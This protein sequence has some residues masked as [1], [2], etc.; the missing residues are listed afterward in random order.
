MA[1]NLGWREAITEVLT[2]AAAPMH[3][4][5]I[6]DQINKLELREDLGATPANSVA[7]II[8]TSIKDFGSQSPFVR[9][10]RG[11]YSLKTAQTA[12]AVPPIVDEIEETT[13]PDTGVINAFGMFWDR[14]KVLWI[15]NPKILGQQ[16][17]NAVEVDFCD[18]KGVYLLHD[19]QGV[20]YVGRVTDQSLGRRLYQHTVDRLN[21]RWGRFSWFGVYRVNP[22]A[23]LSKNDGTT[24]LDMDV[25][26]VTME[27]VLIEGLE[28]R[29]NRKRG[30][31]VQALEFLQK[32]D[33][34]LLRDRK[35][36]V[37]R[38]LLE[39]IQKA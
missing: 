30:D 35:V 9:V 12:A 24:S 19:A 33:P 29:Q 16:Q 23:S 1:Q 5:D 28:P 21:G 32:E 13:S 14:S 10:S 38:E 4:A 11:V 20:V 3:Y 18:Q 37:A 15:P 36:A 2:V 31:D 27:A 22:D 6:A 26:I 34:N 25:V 17:T 8:T 7:A 39:S